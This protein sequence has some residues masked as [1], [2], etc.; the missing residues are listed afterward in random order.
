MATSE[1]LKCIEHMKSGES[2]GLRA[3]P[4]LWRKGQ[5]YGRIHHCGKCD[6]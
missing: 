1:S 5:M 2:S 6:G 3:S 4:A